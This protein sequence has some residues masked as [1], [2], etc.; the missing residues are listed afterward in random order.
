[1]RN[2]FSQES[3]ELDETQEGGWENAEDGTYAAA[4]RRST[5]EPSSYPRR[6]AK[7]EQLAQEFTRSALFDIESGLWG[8]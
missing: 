7:T 6:H 1:V 8:E 2:E 4:R 3:E 5:G